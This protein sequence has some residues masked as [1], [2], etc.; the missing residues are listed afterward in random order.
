MFEVPSNPLWSPLDAAQMSGSGLHQVKL[1]ARRSQLRDGL[2]EV[3]VGHLVGVELGAVA[4]QVEDFDV[5]LVSRQPR[6][7]GLGVMDSKV[8]QN[9]KDLP[10]LAANESAHEVDQDVGVERAV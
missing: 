7:H 10:R 9:Q 1:G 6:L 4:E 3:C 2:F 5:L 8:V